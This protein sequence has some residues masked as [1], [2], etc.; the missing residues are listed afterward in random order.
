MKSIETYLA[1]RRW[2][3][4]GAQFDALYERIKGYRQ[5]CIDSYGDGFWV[6]IT[7]AMRDRMDEMDSELHNLHGDQKAAYVEYVALRDAPDSETDAAACPA[8]ADAMNDAIARP[9]PDDDG[10][11]PWYYS[12]DHPDACDG[13]TDAEYDERHPY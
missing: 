12:P 8:P 11:T 4:I 1:M 2:E 6:E 3:E 9:E 5:A 7:Q 13:K 10:G